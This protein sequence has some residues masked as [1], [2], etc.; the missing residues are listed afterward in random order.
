MTKEET[1]RKQ[2]QELGIYEVIFEPE[3]KTLCQIEREYTRAKKA[4]SATAEPGKA[5]SVLNDH[6]AVLQKLRAEML[7]HRE[8]LGLTPKALRKVRGAAPEGPEQKD[9]ITAALDRIADR[10]SG[11]GSMPADPEELRQRLEEA[12]LAPDPYDEIEA[13]LMRSV[14][15][16]ME[17]LPT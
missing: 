5:P 7:Q 14:N 4:W 6:Y 9:L 12:G 13:E 10:V 1:Y 2:M 8:S 11:Y 16:D 3:I 15:A 17:M